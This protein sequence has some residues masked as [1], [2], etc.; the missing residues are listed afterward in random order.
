MSSDKNV[1]EIVVHMQDKK[2]PFVVD[3]IIK[4]YQSENVYT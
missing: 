1:I 4:A 2:L 3:L